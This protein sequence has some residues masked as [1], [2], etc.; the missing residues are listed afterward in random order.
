MAVM[1]WGEGMRVGVVESED[2]MEEGREARKALSMLIVRGTCDRNDVS[3]GS[4]TKEEVED[5]EEE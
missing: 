5:G 2:T 4:P 3:R 1:F